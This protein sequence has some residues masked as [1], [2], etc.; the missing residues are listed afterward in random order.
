MRASQAGRLAND[1]AHANTFTNP[2]ATVWLVTFISVAP[3]LYTLLRR[4][5]VSILKCSL[6]ICFVL[7]HQAWEVICM[8][9]TSA[10]RYHL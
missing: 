1:L 4:L 2:E 5:F 10:A 6:S 7:Q 3:S 9:L 8:Q